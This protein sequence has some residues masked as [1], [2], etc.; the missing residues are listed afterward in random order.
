DEVSWE[1]GEGQRHSLDLAVVRSNG[2]QASDGWYEF[3]TFD[4]MLFLPVAA[5]IRSVTVRGRCEAADLSAFVAK[6]E[7][8]FQALRTQLVQSRPPLTTTLYVDGGQGFREE[9]CSQQTL[10]EGGEF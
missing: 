8:R 4:P 10:P 3:D 7:Q 2:T 6:S 1:D 5:K 9:L